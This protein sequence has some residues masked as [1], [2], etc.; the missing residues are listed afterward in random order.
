MW[1]LLF[2]QT[3]A[4]TKKLKVNLKLRIV[5][6]KTRKGVIAV[7]KTGNSIKVYK[8]CKIKVR[9][10]NPISLKVEDIVKKRWDIILPKLETIPRLSTRDWKGLIKYAK[11]YYDG[12][13]QKQYPYIVVTYNGNVTHTRDNISYHATSK[14]AFFSS[15]YKRGSVFLKNKRRK[16]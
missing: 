7:R 16:G 2:F 11:V 6:Q 10:Y 14:A 5:N 1:F 12:S 4:K 3:M 8:H 13:Y 15:Y 9:K